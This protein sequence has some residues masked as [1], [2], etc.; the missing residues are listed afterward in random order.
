M[1][2]ELLSLSQIMLLSRSWGWRFVC[3]CVRICVRSPLG[4]CTCDT[5]E[6]SWGCVG[7]TERPY[8]WT[9]HLASSQVIEEE[10]GRTATI[11]VLPMQPGDVVRTSAGIQK[12]QELLGFEPAV[13][14]RDGIRE[15]GPFSRPDAE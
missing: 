11:Q 5:R 12:A 14:V 7:V 13:S 2:A 1:V 4:V 15:V 8:L 3:A 6:S 10:L 9:H